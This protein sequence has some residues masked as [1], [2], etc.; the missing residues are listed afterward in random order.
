MTMSAVASR[1]TSAYRAWVVAVVMVGFTLNFID[2]QILTLLLQPLKAEFRISDAMLG[3]LSG[4]AFALL[5]TT[6]CIPIA[7]LAD[8]ASRS[9]ILALSIGVWSV[10]TIACGAAQ[11][12]LQLALA[13]V[14]VGVGEAGYTPTAISLISD[15]VRPERR[16]TALG[17]AQV[18]IP[19]GIVGGLLVGGWGLQHFGWRG[20]F[21]LAGVP[22]VVLAVVFWLTVREPPRSGHGAPS[23]PVPFRDALRLLWQN[24]AYRYIVFANSAAAVCVYG[25]ATWMPS[26]LIRAFALSAPSVGYLLAPALGVAGALG[27]VAGGVAGDALAARSGSRALWLCAGASVLAI[28]CIFAA[29]FAPTPGL[30]VAIYAVAYLLGLLYAAP[31]VALICGIVPADLRAQAIAVMLFAM[32]LLGLGLGPLLIGRMSDA[33]GA[34]GTALGRALAVVSLCYLPAALCYVLA[35]RRLA[36]TSARPAAGLEVRSSAVTNA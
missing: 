4:A 18:G 25:V 28:P 33:F 17:I 34:S 14:A 8:R 22:G 7:R 13:R 19:L 24:R 16:A 6:L 12:V 30:A 32:N 1:S 35:A 2:R 21:V 31:T 26:F 10:A 27:F 11:N 3:L 23:A 5:H 20:A 15:L 29:T 9:R 36:M